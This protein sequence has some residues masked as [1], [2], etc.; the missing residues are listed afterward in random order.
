MTGPLGCSN[1]TAK[2]VFMTVRAVRCMSVARRA[3]ATAVSGEGTRRAEALACTDLRPVLLAYWL[4]LIQ[5]SLTPVFYASLR[6]LCFAQSL[7]Q[8]GA[9]HVRKRAV[10]LAPFMFALAPGVAK[11]KRAS[12]TA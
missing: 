3:A 5:A 1:K 10:L 9:I 8:P 12:C 6:L 7:L 4:E 2:A 11:R